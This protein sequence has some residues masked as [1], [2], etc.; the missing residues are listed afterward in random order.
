MKKYTT[1]F[2]DLDHTLW[3]F[4]ANSKE[5]LEEIYVHQRLQRRGIPSFNEFLNEYYK[6][7]DQMWALYRRDAITKDQLRTDR[8]FN[9]LLKFNIEDRFL[10]T[11]MGDYYVNTS[12]HKTN[13]FEG[14]H[15]VLRELS[16]KYE[17]HIITNGFDEVQHIKIEKSRLDEYFDQVITSEIAG[18]KKP[19][20]RIFE[21]TLDITQTSKEEGLMIG[22]GIETD[23]FGARN[24]GMDQVYF[25]P[26]KNS[27]PVEATYE[28]SQLSELLDLLA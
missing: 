6:I 15:D 8:F 3:D 4:D 5:A 14:C 26:N 23:I 11:E 22:D 2:F 12:P 7:N 19:D 13:L 24:F 9:T 1:L 28:I 16:Q 17:M 25:N 20:S 10:A 18:S 27:Q 21:Y